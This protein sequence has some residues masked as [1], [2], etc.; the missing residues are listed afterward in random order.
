MAAMAHASLVRFGSI[1]SL[2]AFVAGCETRGAPPAPPATAKPPASSAASSSPIPAMS[3]AAATPP[4]SLT[5]APAPD[6]SV[7][8]IL[9]FDD[10]PEGA[11]PTTLEPVLGDWSIARA[12]DA[13]GVMVDGSRSKNASAPASAFYPL[14]LTRSGAPNGDMRISVRFYPLAGAIDQAAGLAFG[15]APD[16]S[17]TG[18]RA[19]ALEANL[20]FFK[21]VKGKRNVV[22]T[23]SGVPTATRTWHTL[24]LELRGAT[25]R[26]SID[27]TKRLEKRLD[28]IP[29]GR[30]GLWSK[31]DSKVLFD[32][33]EITP[34]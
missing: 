33:L 24:E 9:R 27:G 22:E 15:V 5:T 18:V 12:G 25:V 6:A 30:V 34:L 23:V 10:E 32:D 31:A 14:A 21:V 1:A 20:L 26:V 13:K 29:R 2:A 11:A 28:P 19:N 3:S 8:T 7:G 17:Y 4:P 16:G